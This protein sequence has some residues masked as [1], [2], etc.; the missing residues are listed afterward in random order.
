M[1]PEASALAAIASASSVH[2]LVNTIPG[3]YRPALRRYI[4]KQYQRIRNRARV[5]Q[6][7]SSLQRHLQRGT[8]PMSIR[9]ALKV[10]IL[11][12]DE[13][14]TRTPEGAAA[15][16]ALH[17]RVYAA[18]RSTLRAVIS[19]AA[20]ELA[21]LSSRTDTNT[22]AWRRDWER[23]VTATASGLV[24]AYGSS[25]GRD[26]EG[27]YR[28]AGMTP[29]AGADF[30]TILSTATAYATRLLRLAHGAC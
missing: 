9:D 4:I 30:S 24:Q 14:F 21:F 15:V 12:I 11:S 10:P 27:A 28:I 2:D 18:R 1:R 25:L 22:A 19:Q 16:F 3:P 5:A 26:A 20:T 13:S 6:S 7:L 29:E 23:L 17:A 8:F